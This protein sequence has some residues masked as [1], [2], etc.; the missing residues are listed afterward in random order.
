MAFDY[1]SDYENFNIT[2]CIRLF[3]SCD[4]LLCIVDVS[5]KIV[6]WNPSTRQHHQLPPIPNPNMLEFLT[7]CG[8]GYDSSSD[9][10][11]V[12]VVYT[13]RYISEE[14]VVDVFSLKSNKWKNIKE[15]HHTTV[16]HTTLG[17]RDATV[18]RGA[19][20][21]LNSSTSYD[22]IRKLKLYKITAF[23]FEKEEFREMSIPNNDNDR[24]FKLTVVGGCLCLYR[25]VG[26]ERVW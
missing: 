6:I 8:F 4:G 26:Y 2:Y 9:D 23:D 3:S 15:I 17:T 5:G 1:I 13:F 21:W 11:K 14:T 22:G 16:H 10:Y 12:I 19:L 18:L 7:C 25:D 24:H 20:H